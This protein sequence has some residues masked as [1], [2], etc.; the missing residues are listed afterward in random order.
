M[1]TIVA[2]LGTSGAKVVKC[3]PG[4]AHKPALYDLSLFQKKSKSYKNSTEFLLDHFD[5]SFIFIGTQ[6]AIE[7]QKE[8]LQKELE[9]KN[10]RYIEVEDNDLDDIFENIFTIL[11]RHDEVLLDITHG[12]RHQPIMAIF[13]STLS[14]FLHNKSLQI[15]FAK[16]EVRL[17]KYRYIYLE[18]YIEITQLS[19]LLTGFI[20]TLNFIPLK[21]ITLFNAKVFE[22]FSKSLLSNDLK[23]VEK[24][25][26]LLA[27]ELEKLM[28]HRELQHLFT[29]FGE[30]KSTLSPLN[31]LKEKETTIY[32]KYLILS[33]ITL[34]KNYIVVALAY[35]FE[36][37]REYCTYG[38]SPYLKG[39][40]IKKGYELNTVVMDTIG[41]FKRNGRANK[42]QKRYPRLY[43]NNKQIFQ[44]IA[45]I[46]KEIRVLRNDLA[47]INYEKDFKDIKQMIL[48][49]GF[50]VEVLFREDVLQKI[51][52]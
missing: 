33:Q 39:I 9:N 25:Y 35:L 36:A 21:N 42:I 34:D 2:I 37:I 40:S 3:L 8:L 23:G 18:E 4:E 50:K 27:D 16:E 45:H 1:K 30:I 43:E 6:C 10:V 32:H 29:L 7:F 12:F 46:Y 11:E 49:I 19:L 48:K 17:E 20:R 22:D 44:R 14:K 47:H 15:I 52:V 26:T 13:A 41:N 24:N 51:V 31:I 38:F 28:R 5:E